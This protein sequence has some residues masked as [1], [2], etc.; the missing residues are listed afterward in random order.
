MFILFSGHIIPTPALAVKGKTP[1]PHSQFAIQRCKSGA[2]ISRHLYPA[3]WA[4]V[5]ST[6]RLLQRSQSFLDVREV[7]RRER[8]GLHWHYPE[9]VFVDFLQP[10]DWPHLPAD[11]LDLSFQCD[12]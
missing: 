5:Y 7:A 10:L 8:F 3:C 12:G 11:F 6:L 2:A 4:V 9:Q 1:L